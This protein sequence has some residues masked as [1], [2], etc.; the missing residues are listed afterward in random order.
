M[1]PLTAE[2]SPNKS[3]KLLSPS[4]TSIKG[5]SDENKQDR[6]KNTVASI[7][8]QSIQLIANN[9]IK[10]QPLLVTRNQNPLKHRITLN[11]P[12]QDT[13]SITPVLPKTKC[14]GGPNSI[15]S[16]ING[17][18]LNSPC[19]NLGGPHTLSITPL[20]PNTADASSSLSTFSVSSI[21]KLRSSNCKSTAPCYSILSV[22]PISAPKN[23]TTDSS[24]P[25]YRL[26][27]TPPSSAST[28]DKRHQRSH[29]ANEIVLQTA[30]KDEETGFPSV[31]PQAESPSP[32][33]GP[34]DE[35]S[36]QKA[37]PCDDTPCSS[38][39]TVPLSRR[40]ARERNRVRQVKGCTSP[41]TL[42][43]RVR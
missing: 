10:V 32:N 7:H 18:T 42:S 16:K 13:V 1:A 15:T 41:L 8:K 3:V 29:L 11:T 34:G 6:A 33:A 28:Q 20:S 31:H 30:C 4:P 27:D 5:G 9:P 17:R 39:P 23:L 35:A 38:Q 26:P 19:D 37:R 12:S 21:D 40:N 36:T 22:T 43:T 25:C 14:V 2:Y 24:S